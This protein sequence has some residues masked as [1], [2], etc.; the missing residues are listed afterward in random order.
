MLDYI[1]VSRQAF[2]FNSNLIATVFWCQK[3]D[4]EPSTKDALA[5]CL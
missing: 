2:G 4:E 5:R 1:E 3:W